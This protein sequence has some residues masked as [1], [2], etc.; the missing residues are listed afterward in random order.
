M[1]ENPLKID[2]SKQAYWENYKDISWNKIFPRLSSQNFQDNTFFIAYLDY[3][4]IIGRLQNE[5]LSYWNHSEKTKL[6]EKDFIFLQKLRVF[7]QNEELYFWNQG[8]SPRKFSARYR[9][10]VS[11]NEFIEYVESNQILFGTKVFSNENYSTIKENRGTEII[12]P[13]SNFYLDNKDDDLERIAI[14]T[15][16][17]MD[18][19]EMGLAYY[20]DL[21]FVKFVHLHKE[22]E[23]EL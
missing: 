1:S 7:N 6:E 2:S 18:Y 5:I 8:L 15:R 16:Y 19:N 20:K 22:T 13:F 12:L 23:T 14:K 9:S 4:V 10:D 21:R 11:G 3:K 17:Y